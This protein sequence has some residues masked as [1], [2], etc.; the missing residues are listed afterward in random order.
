[1]EKNLKISGYIVDVVAERIFKGSLIISH[2]KIENIIED[3]NIDCQQYII[4]GFIDSHVH[5][6]SSMLTPANFAH[7]AIKHGTIA[8]VADPHEIGNVLGIEGVEFMIKNGE[9]SPMKFF[10]GAPSCVPATEFET[11]GA[12]I[13]ATDIEKLFK[14]GK[15][16]Y[17]AEMMNYPG[18]IN[19]DPEVMRK[20]EIAHKYNK[21]IDGHAPAITGDDLKKYA[22]SGITTDH[23]CMS[24]QEAVEKIGLGMKI[25]I[26]EGSAAK[27][28]DDL[29]KLGKTHPQKTMLCSDDKHPDDLIKGHINLLYKRAIDVGISPMEALKICSLNPIKH[30]GLD[31][32]LLQK[33]DSADFLLVNNLEELSINEVYIDGEKVFE[34]GNVLWSVP[35]LEEMPNNFQAKKL[36]V[37][38]LKVEAKSENIRIIEIEDGQLYTKNIIAKAKIEDGYAISDTDEDILKIVVL[39]RYK[40]S[41]PQIA[42][43]KNF[44]LKK[45]AIASSIAH[46][47]HNIISVGV[48]DI[49]IVNSINSII[50]AKGGISVSSSN[51]TE[52][53]PLPIAGLMSNLDA[54]TVAQKYEELDKLAK[55]LGTK[56][57]A[58]FMTLAFMSLLVIPEIKLGDKGLFDCINFS[59]IELFA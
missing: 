53:L 46:D 23:E 12:K 43:I 58:P 11:S 35:P 22:Q 13:D 29:I 48:D 40:P 25:Q 18:V 5:I 14:E 47:S 56:L 49:D 59:F 31:V 24:Y 54:K 26:R 52:I 28:F 16:H 27:N 45:G 34:K 20:I 33:G 55:Q 17:L 3:D 37:D 21:K 41:E 57:S 7:E 50:E 2:G 42:F 9:Q 15:V 36:N 39:N 4:P 30:Y 1:M 10:F 19:N 51:G 8:C 44:G 6:E 32:G 38:D